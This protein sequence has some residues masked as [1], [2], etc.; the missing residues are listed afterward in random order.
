MIAV[1][2]KYDQFKR[3]VIIKLEDH[4]RDPGD[5]ND[6]MKR[7]FDKHY[8]ANLGDPPFVHL[9]GKGIVNQLT[10]TMLISIVQTCTKRASNAQNLLKQLPMRF[11]VAQLH[12]FSCQYKRV[13]WS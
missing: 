1:F 5:L 10:C 7:I 12:S 13:I 3:D 4:G 9:E 8:W 11:V 2:T 6:E